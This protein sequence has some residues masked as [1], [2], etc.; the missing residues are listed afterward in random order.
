MKD[1]NVA[2]EPDTQYIINVGSVGQ[3][4]DGDSRACFCVYDSKEKSIQIKRAEYD[5]KSAQLKI[6]KAELPSSLAHRLV[7]GQ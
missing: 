2:I 3:P 1:Y 5:I 7:L 6:L 4:R